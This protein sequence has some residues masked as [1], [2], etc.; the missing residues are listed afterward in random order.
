MRRVPFV[1]KAIRVICFA[2]VLMAPGLAAAEDTTSHYQTAEG[3]AGYI[4][5]VPVQIVKG[6]LAAHP[7]ATMHGGV[8]PGGHQHHLIVALF[9]ANTGARLTNVNV[10]VTVFGPGNTQIYGQAHPKPWGSKAPVVPRTALEPM[11]IAGTTTYGG[12]FWLP[13]PAIYTI[14]IVVSRPEKTKPTILNFAY[15]NSAD[16]P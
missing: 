3:V 16:Q 5:I 6:P 15:D 13:K 9:D 1:A 8:P 7:D 14:Q 10:A 12:F 4:G 11:Q 2:M